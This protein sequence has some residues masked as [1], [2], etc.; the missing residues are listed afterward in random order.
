MSAFK[1]S[2]KRSTILLVRCGDCDFTGC[3]M[4]GDR[5]SEKF[6]PVFINLFDHLFDKAFCPSLFISDCCPSSLR[7]FLLPGMAMDKALRNFLK[8]STF[9]S[10]CNAALFNCWSSMI[11]VRG[12]QRLKNGLLF[13]PLVK[14]EGSRLHS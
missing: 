7:P 9:F 14:T 10:I 5:I 2:K 13:L 3:C 12:L 8:I 1:I 4:D 6:I 11:F